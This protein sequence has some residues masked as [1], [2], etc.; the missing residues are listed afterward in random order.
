[1]IQR[2]FGDAASRCLTA[3]KKLVINVSS[4]LVGR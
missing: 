2:Y 4:I 3:S 1:M